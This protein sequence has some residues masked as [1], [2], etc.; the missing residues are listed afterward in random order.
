MKQGIYLALNTLENRQC[1]NDTLLLCDCKAAI[2]SVSTAQQVDAYNDLVNATRQKLF[3]LKQKGQKI[4]LEWCP[5]HMGW[6]AT[7][8]QI[9]RQS[10]QQRRPKQNRATHGHTNLN[11]YLNWIDPDTSPNCRTCGVR[12]TI[13]HYIHHCGKYDKDMYS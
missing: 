11:A 8:W 1:R 4:Q 10:W 6:K 9:S 5:G 7:S 2:Q 13:D 12:E 3:E